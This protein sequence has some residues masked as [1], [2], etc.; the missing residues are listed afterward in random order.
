M[1]GFFG[2]QVGQ[3]ILKI[4]PRNPP[5]PTDSKISLGSYFWGVLGVEVGAGLRWHGTAKRMHLGAE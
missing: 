3:K 5:S 1:V 2:A 4:R